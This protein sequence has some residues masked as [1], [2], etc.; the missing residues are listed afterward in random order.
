MG[1]FPAYGVGN[2]TATFCYDLLSRFSAL[3]RFLYEEEI[4]PTN[5][6][7]ERGLRPVVIFRKLSG[8]S[9]SEWGT[10]FIERLFTVACTLK[11]RAGNLFEYLSQSF[12][13]Y[14]HGTPG[15]PLPSGS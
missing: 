7:A 14:I 3:W 13:A 12:Q 8:G 6:L 2:K 9:H 15:P 11:Q 1:L 5:N 4:E 10:Q